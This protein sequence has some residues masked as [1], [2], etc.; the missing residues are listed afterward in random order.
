MVLKYLLG[1]DF[2]F[3]LSFFENGEASHLENQ[4]RSIYPIIIDLDLLLDG[5]LGQMRNIGVH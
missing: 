3:L 2:A 1:P 4:M 5:V